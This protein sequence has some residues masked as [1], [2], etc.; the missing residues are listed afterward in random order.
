MACNSFFWVSFFSQNI[1]SFSL[2]HVVDGCHTV[3][4][5]I[6][7]M[8]APAAFLWTSENSGLICQSVRNKHKVFSSITHRPISQGR[9]GSLIGFEYWSR[10]VVLSPG[11][12]TSEDG[13]LNFL[14]WMLTAKWRS[15]K[16]SLA[17]VTCFL[18]VNNCV[19]GK[20][21]AKLY[22]TEGSCFLVGMVI[23]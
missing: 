18:D 9:W 6:K 14:L 7:V 2:G 23:P 10:Q 8:C 4:T 11:C 1:L 12:I 13:K 17:L 20:E 16:P 5:V 21:D 3:F 22:V 15:V 19:V